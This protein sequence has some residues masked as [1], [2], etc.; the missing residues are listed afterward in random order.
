M[1]E[2]GPRREEAVHVERAEKWVLILGN[3]H[4]GRLI[5]MFCLKTKGAKFHEFIKSVVLGA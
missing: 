1:L 5:P 3:S 4:G 2:A